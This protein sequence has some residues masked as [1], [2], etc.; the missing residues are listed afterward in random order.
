MA[1][2]RFL[3]LI[4]GALLAPWA[5]GC[6]PSPFYSMGFLTPIPIPAW[7]PE[8]ME[9]KYCYKNDHRTPI[10]PPITEGAPLPLCEDPPDEAAVLRAMPQVT[11]GIPYV[12]EEH[13]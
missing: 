2:L 7:V 8:R 1:K 12:Y 10:M 11:R 13:R 3:T 6:H 4:A 5:V 9:Q